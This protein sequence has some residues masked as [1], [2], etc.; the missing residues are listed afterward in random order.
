MD[1]FNNNSSAVCDLLVEATIR[2][3]NSGIVKPRFEAEY[4]LQAVLGMSK[5]ELF[6]YADKHVLLADMVKYR[7]MV[8][9]RLKQEPLQYI[10]GKVEFWSREFQV[11][12]DVLIPRQDTEFVLEQVVLHLRRQATPCR[13]ILDMGTGSG[14]IAD[15]LAG[16]LECRVV[17]VDISTAALEIAQNNIASHD[18]LDKVT[19]IHSDLFASLPE[20]ELF[21]CIVSNPPYVAEL[22]KKD[23]HP[24]VVEFEPAGALFAGADGLDCY[25]DLI[26]ESIH[27]LEPGGWLCLEIGASQGEEISAMLHDNGYH[28]VEILSDYAGHSRLALGR[29]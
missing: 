20:T 28:D 17:A 22:D 16:E 3:E 10:V 11:T 26:P 5:A 7:A 13:K 23:L 9:R 12:P 1:P 15:V 19:F 8:T 25:R 4:L 29:K 24:E 27:Y 18:L 2:L 6:L 21:D 14:V